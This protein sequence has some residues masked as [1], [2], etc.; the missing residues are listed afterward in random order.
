MN[1]L[2]T[3]P[4]SHYCEK[5]R[6]GLEISKIP[7]REERH[8]QGFHYFYTKPHSSWTV[9]ILFTDDGIRKDSTDILKWADAHSQSDVRLYT[10]DL[11]TKKQ[12]EDLE[13]DFDEILGPSGRLWMYSYTF[14]FLPLL[15]RYSKLHNV[16]VHELRLMPMFFVVLKPFAKKRLGWNKMSRADAKKIVD[17]VFDRVGFLL[18]D[19]RRFLVGNNFSAAD[20]TFA[21]LAAAVLVPEQYGVKLPYLDEL[22]AEM[23]EQIKIWRNHP[24]G[25]FALRM[26]EEFR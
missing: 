2:L 21:S 26:Y 15:I 3:I 9:P 7:F 24:A 11:Q 23:A 22:P 8:L 1:R 18:Q 10:E 5:A 25:K 14:D 13:N 6:W 17:Q 4:I 19:G 12:I 20:L 16:P